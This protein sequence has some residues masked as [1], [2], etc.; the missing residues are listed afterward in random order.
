ML[1]KAGADP[2][3]VEEDGWNAM[4]FAALNGRGVVVKMLLAYKQLIDS[5]SKSGAT[6]LMCAA[7]KGHLEICEMLLKAARI[8]SLWKR[9]AGTLCFCCREW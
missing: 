7:D 9:M 1:L 3:A 4:Y 2:L 8:H 6:P 5:K